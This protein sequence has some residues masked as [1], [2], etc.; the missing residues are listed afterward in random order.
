M[1]QSNRL[2]ARLPVGTRYVLEARGAE[3]HRYVE[4][5]NGRRISLPVRATAVCT[6]GEASLVPPL[7]SAKKA[8][9]KTRVRAFA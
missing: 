2:P 1:A 5:P 3:V 4:L 9:P 8:R 7:P 6:A